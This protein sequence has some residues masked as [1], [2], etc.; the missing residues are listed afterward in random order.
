MATANVQRPMA[1]PV[2]LWHCLSGDPP[3]PVLYD[4]TFLNATHAS[5]LAVKDPELTRA[6]HF[7]VTVL[8]GSDGKKVPLVLKSTDTIGK[9][10]KSFLQKQPDLTGSLNLAYNGK[11]VQ[12]HQSLGELG[13]KDG[14]TFITFQR[15][16]GG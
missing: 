8:N 10:Q 1:L 15:C 2:R 5:L 6:S 13:V 7:T 16:H 3:I 4:P 12:G 11:P 9:L 14:A